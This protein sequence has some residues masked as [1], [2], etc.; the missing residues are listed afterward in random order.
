MESA[1]VSICS[2]SLLICPCLVLELPALCYLSQVLGVLQPGPHPHSAPH[3]W[4]RRCKGRKS[5]DRMDTLLIQAVPRHRRGGSG[6]RDHNTTHK[7]SLYRWALCVSRH[8]GCVEPSRAQPLG[9]DRS[10][11]LGQPDSRTRS[12]DGGCVQHGARLLKS[13]DYTH[14]GIMPPPSSFPQWVRYS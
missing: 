11:R 9:E 2:G 10:G 7:L 13:H 4:D 3:T 14:L 8:M 12:M 5:Q 1:W 6:R